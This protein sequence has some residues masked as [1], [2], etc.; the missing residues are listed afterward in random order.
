VYKFECSRIAFPEKEEEEEEEE[1]EVSEERKGDNTTD[2]T[3][4]TLS[5]DHLDR[6]LTPT[7]LLS[8]L[9]DALLAT[10]THP[11]IPTHPHPPTHT[12]THSPTP[13]YTHTQTYKKH[14][15]TKT[16]QGLDEVSTTGSFSTWELE[17]VLF[18]HNVVNTHVLEEQEREN[19]R[20]KNAYDDEW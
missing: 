8:S 6:I 10:H 13:T 11:L 15:H 12:P 9:G 7:S 18:K 1:E 3:E 14:L 2:D 5:S 20:G 16:M 17:K 19:R 4:R